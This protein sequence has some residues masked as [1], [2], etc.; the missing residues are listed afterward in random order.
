[1]SGIPDLQKLRALLGSPGGECGYP[2]NDATLTALLEKYPCYE[3]AAYQACLL[4]ARSDAV[5]LPDGTATPDQSGYWKRLALTFR[6]NRGGTVCRADR[7]E[8]ERDG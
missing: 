2:L 4:M 3:L 6:P 5:R 7:P 1:M 8:D